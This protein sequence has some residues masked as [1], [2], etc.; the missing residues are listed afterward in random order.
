MRNFLISNISKDMM[1]PLKGP[2]ESH[3]FKP[4]ERYITGILSPWKTDTNQAAPLQDECIDVSLGSTKQNLSVDE[5][6]IDN[7]VS[8]VGG[9]EGLSP[10][11]DPRSYPKNMGLS[12]NVF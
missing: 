12:F 10:V 9:D 11:I 4:T 7:G 1:G 5:D 3:V 6:S 8:A 2:H